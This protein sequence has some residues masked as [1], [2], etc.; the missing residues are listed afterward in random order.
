MAPE[1]AAESDFH[2]T[3]ARHKNEW[4]HRVTTTDKPTGY[5][6]CSWGGEMCLSLTISVKATTEA[7]ALEKAL[8]VSKGL[9]A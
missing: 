4:K 7:E 3:L 9:T 5:G 8:R 6:R 2:V 1:V